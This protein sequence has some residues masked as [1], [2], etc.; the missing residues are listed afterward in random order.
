MKTYRYRLLFVKKNNNKPI[1][2]QFSRTSSTNRL[3]VQDKK[4]FLD[5]ANLT[6]ICLSVISLVVQ[7]EQYVR[8][9]CVREISFELNEF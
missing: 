2:N 1:I 3:L 5:I 6:T 4:E 9:V 7:V 8:F